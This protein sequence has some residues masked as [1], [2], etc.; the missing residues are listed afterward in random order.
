[1]AIAA[2]GSIPSVHSYELHEA[3]KNSAERVSLYRATLDQMSKDIKAVEAYLVASGVNFR[4]EY[5]FDS[6]LSEV[7]IEENDFHGV[8]LIGT[9]HRDV[10]AWA[11]AEK[12][13]FRLMFIKTS[14]VGVTADNSGRVYEYDGAGPIEVL[15]EKA[16]IETKAQVRAKA[17]AHLPKFVAALANALPA[18]TDLSGVFCDASL[19]ETGG[20]NANA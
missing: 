1:M 4:F 3:L 7:S 5:E 14:Q 8:H 19:F 11:N 6:R 16:L 18:P 17:Y 13:G 15:E 20:P 10:L 9:N 2:D 12:S